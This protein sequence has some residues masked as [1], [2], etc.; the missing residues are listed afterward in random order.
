MVGRVPPRI[1]L[2]LMRQERIKRSGD[3]FLRRLPADERQ[4]LKRRIRIARKR[5]AAREFRR[6]CDEHT[7]CPTCGV[8]MRIDASHVNWETVHG[9]PSDPCDD[10]CAAALPAHRACSV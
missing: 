3:R 10:W 8:H 2:E 4:V 1:V 9:G 5:A 7:H 6:L